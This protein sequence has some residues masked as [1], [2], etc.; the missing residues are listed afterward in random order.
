MNIHISSNMPRVHDIH[1]SSSQKDYIHW[2][3]MR[4]DQLLARL[5][6]LPCSSLCA[7]GKA[8]MEC[9]YY[10]NHPRICMHILRFLYIYGIVYLCLYV[11]MCIYFWYTSAYTY[12]CS[13][14]SLMLSHYQH[15][16][17]GPGKGK[18]ALNHDHMPI[19]A[20]AMAKV[21]EL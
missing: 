11:Y 16:Q 3:K 17:S 14:I 15:R 12:V 7:Y 6:G 5:Q 4:P 2:S 10:C 8:F 18:S 21:I 19:Y 9:H 1:V 13:H 20:V